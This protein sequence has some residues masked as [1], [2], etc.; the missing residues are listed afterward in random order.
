MIIVSALY[1]MHKSSLIS[2]VNY[3]IR[4]EF[5]YKGIGLTFFGL[6]STSV[7]SYRN[8]M[9][10]QCI[11]AINC[12]NQYLTFQVIIQ[13]WYGTYGMLSAMLPLLQGIPSLVMGERHAVVL[14]RALL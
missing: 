14:A 5:P 4:L 12:C 9:Q 3:Y 8:I 6:A 1:I 13:H 2:G 10:G 7:A 11:I